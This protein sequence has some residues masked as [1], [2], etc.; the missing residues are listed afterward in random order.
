MKISRPPQVAGQPQAD[1]EIAW[2]RELKQLRVRVVQLEAER[3][4]AQRPSLGLERSKE[5]GYQCGMPCGVTVSENTPRVECS[6]C[7]TKLDPVQVLRDY[8]HHE[9]NFCYSLE[10][11]R[12]EQ[13]K[14]LAENDKLKALRLR[15][16]AQARKMLPEPPAGGRNKYERDIVANIQLDRVLA[17]DEVP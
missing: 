11:L 16:R 17:E 8:A 10:H 14:L 9:R 7:G 1:D 5:H 13:A 2:R 4:I 12:K 15:L 3:G 6:A